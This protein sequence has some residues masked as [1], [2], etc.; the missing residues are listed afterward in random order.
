MGLQEN[1]KTDLRLRNLTIYAQWM[2]TVAATSLYLIGVPLLV[3]YLFHV[4]D[5]AASAWYLVESLVRAL[6]FPLAPLALELPHYVRRTPFLYLGM[7]SWVVFI[8]HVAISDFMYPPGS[9]ELDLWF[10]EFVELSLLNVT[11][12]LACSSIFSAHVTRS[13]SDFKIRIAVDILCCVHLTVGWFEPVP[14]GYEA[15][16]NVRI[17]YLVVAGMF[18]IA[19]FLCAA[20]WVKRHRWVYSVALGGTA[21]EPMVLTVPVGAPRNQSVR[22]EAREGAIRLV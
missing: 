8:T 16:Q 4:S 12:Y 2:S 3:A 15:G 21:I 11:M 5:V 19:A 17:F 14:M 7:A 18:A 13:P 1:V 6:L 10:R 9:I 20:A 22:G